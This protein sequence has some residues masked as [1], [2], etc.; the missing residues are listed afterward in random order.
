[1]PE[2]VFALIVLAGP[3]GALIS[4]FNRVLMNRNASWRRTAVM[5][6]SAT[7]LGVI[8]PIALVVFHQRGVLYD[9]AHFRG[10]R[11]AVWLLGFYLTILL[12]AIARFLWVSLITLPRRKQ[13]SVVA[14]ENRAIRPYRLGKGEAEEKC[15]SRT[16]R[17]IARLNCHFDLEVNEFVLLLS[18]LPKSFD[19]FSIVQI[20]DLHA[21]HSQPE[22]WRE[23]VTETVEQLRPNLIAVTGD[24]LARADDLGRVERM[25]SRLK[26]PHGVWVVR[27]N[28]DFWETPEKLRELFDRCGIGL[29]ANRRVEIHRNGECL[30]LVGIEWPWDRSH[31]KWRD[32]FSP[33]PARVTVVLSHTPDTAPAVAQLGAT[34]M[35]AGHTHGGQ[36]RLPFVG[37]LVVPSRYGKRYEQGW[38]AVGSLALYVN[39][40]IGT[41]APAVRVACRPEVARFVLRWGGANLRD[42]VVSP[43]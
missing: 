35:L 18:G 2:I 40:G 19:G 20:S 10:P 17:L 13:P 14:A 42:R 22:S 25:L 24:F 43:P 30:D 23:F 28:H 37:S 8:P 15:C 34:L 36:I 29:L 1:M 11:A 4:L 31:D 9:I 5:I 38:F 12:I 16:L 6:L 41:H 27:G 39:R 7:V 33:R 21:S 3:V 32:V 26:A